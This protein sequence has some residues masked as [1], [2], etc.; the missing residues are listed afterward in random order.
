M[1]WSDLK[2]NFWWLIDRYLEGSGKKNLHSSYNIE[3]AAA[4]LYKMFLKF[5]KC[6]YLAKS[7]C[8]RVD[9]RRLK[10]SPP[11]VLAIVLDTSFGW[12]EWV[13]AYV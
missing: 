9:F 2:R 12:H 5:L 6:F 8:R 4:V 10:H 3:R 7:L 13:P 11:R 1:S